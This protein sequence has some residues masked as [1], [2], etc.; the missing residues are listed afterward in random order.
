MGTDGAPPRE[1]G[2]AALA[3]RL[4][5]LDA[6]QGTATN[7][8]ALNEALRTLE[9]QWLLDGGIP[10]RPWFR[11]ALYAPR[12]TYAAMELPGV[13]E[14]IDAKNWALATRELGRLTARIEAVAQ[15]T[16]D[17]LAAAGR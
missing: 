9:Q 7:L 4:A 17:A 11:H 15:K 6:G 13:R 12:Y 2:R 10:G 5:A 14:A 16:S 8:A 1:R 3:S